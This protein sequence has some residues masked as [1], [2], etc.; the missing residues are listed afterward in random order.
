MSETEG[1]RVVERAATSEKAL[2]RAR[3]LSARYGARFAIVS[4]ESVGSYP[5]AIVTR[6][7]KLERI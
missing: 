2:V 4:D 1:L 6:P 5:F 3:G 7:G